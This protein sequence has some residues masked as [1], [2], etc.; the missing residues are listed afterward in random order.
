MDNSLSERIA[1]RQLNKND[2][3]RSRHKVTFMAHKNDIDEALLAGWSMKLI[4]ETLK[5]EEKISF[6]YKTFR[7]YV[8]KFIS[9]ERNSYQENTRKED[10]VIIDAS[11]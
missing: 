6:S 10:K 5:E 7:T 4:W 1:K 2:S 11:V 8:L 3:G 9:S